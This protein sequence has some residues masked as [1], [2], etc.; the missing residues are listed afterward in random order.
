MLENIIEMH[1]LTH[2]ITL[3]MSGTI[4]LPVMLFKVVFFF[5]SRV[6]FYCSFYTMECKI[7]CL[8]VKN[9]FL[10]CWAVEDVVDPPCLC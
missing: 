6:S 3:I 5:Y 4:Q 8:V 1:C 7:T 2:C 9:L 10:W